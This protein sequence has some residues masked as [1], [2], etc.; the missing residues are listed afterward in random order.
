[1]RD[2]LRSHRCVDLHRMAHIYGLLKVLYTIDV[3]MRNVAQE[4]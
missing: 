3:R 4:N 2:G 1:M